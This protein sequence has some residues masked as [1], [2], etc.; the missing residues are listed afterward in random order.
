M[1]PLYSRVLA[2]RE[3]RL[4]RAL[5]AETRLHGLSSL[6][7]DSCSGFAPRSE[8][9]LNSARSSASHSAVPTVQTQQVSMA[10]SAQAMPSW[11]S[12]HPCRPARVQLPRQYSTAPWESRPAPS[13]ARVSTL[14]T[15]AVVRVSAVA[16]WLEGMASRYLRRPHP[17]AGHRQCSSRSRSMQP[18]LQR[19]RRKSNVSRRESRCPRHKEPGC[20]LASFSSRSSSS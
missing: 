20:V 1:A 5:V 16:G 3:S 4:H 18:P 12:T 14:Y 11:R 9:S 7:H 19:P 2:N 6:A 15:V 13:S 8:N 17:L 10:L